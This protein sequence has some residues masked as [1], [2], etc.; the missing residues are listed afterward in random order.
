MTVVGFYKV[1]VED[2][3]SWFIWGEKMFLLNLDWKKT[4]AELCYFFANGFL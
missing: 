3:Q 2:F 1:L 4:L